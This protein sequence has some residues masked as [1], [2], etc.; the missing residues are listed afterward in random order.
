MTPEER[1][2]KFKELRRHSP[3]DPRA[4]ERADAILNGLRARALQ[5]KNLEVDCNASER[6]KTSLRRSQIFFSWI[7]SDYQDEGRRKTII[8]ALVNINKKA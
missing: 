2:R 6:S 7:A 3:L 8:E 4:Q 5:N 1:Y